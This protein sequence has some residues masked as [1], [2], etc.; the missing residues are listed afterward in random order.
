MLPLLRDGTTILNIDESW[1]HSTNFTRKTWSQTGTLAT[2]LEKPISY[3]IALIAALDTEGRIYYSLTQANTDQNVMMVYLQHLLDQLDLERP[4][5]KD[6]TVLLLDG[7][8]Y[9]TGSQVR[10]YLRKLEV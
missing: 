7:A 3:R 4:S 8:R 1:V 2:I 5:W 9:H 10:E 6:D